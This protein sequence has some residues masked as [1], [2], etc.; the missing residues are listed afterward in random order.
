MILRKK[1]PLLLVLN[2]VL[3]ILLLNLSGCNNIEE[4]RVYK[5]YSVEEGNVHFTF[6]YPAEFNLGAIDF[7]D[8][9]YR[10]VRFLG[11]K[12]DVQEGKII[13]LKQARISVDIF[14]QGETVP[15]AESILA[16]TIESNGKY[17]D[18]R[19]IK[20]Y[21]TK[22]S[23]IEATVLHFSNSGEGSD[24]YGVISYYF[25][26]V[27]WSIYFEHNGH[28]WWIEFSYPVEMSAEANA[29]FEHILKTFKILD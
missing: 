7:E 5:L 21:T 27:D 17:P 22:I 14:E 1:T 9:F 8:D 23:G 24:A 4:D 18:F 10:F 26:I 13:Q 15:S 20:R 11:T 19:E 12:M 16:E 2:T 28:V 6:E 25:D 29:D 3:M